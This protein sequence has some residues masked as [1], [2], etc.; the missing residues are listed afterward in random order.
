ML[1]QLCTLVV[2]LFRNCTDTAY[3]AFL[4]LGRGGGRKNR[5]LSRYLVTESDALLAASAGWEGLYRL[6]ACVFY[7][8]EAGEENWSVCRMWEFG[9]RSLLLRA[10][11]K[12]FTRKACYSELADT[13]KTAVRQTRAL[14]RTKT[15]NPTVKTSPKLKTL[16]SPVISWCS[17]G[18]IHWAY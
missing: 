2:W 13:G 17:H 7:C 11:K 5:N 3:S 8:S 6:C 12:H 18:A 10:A 14:S 4:R 9:G 16:L 1:R 15:K